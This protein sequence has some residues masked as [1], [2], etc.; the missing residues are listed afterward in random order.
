[1][2]AS[3]SDLAQD[4]PHILVVDPRFDAYKALAAAARL[5][6]ID[7]HFRSAGRD[8]LKLAKRMPVDAW[9]IGAELDDMSGEDFVS[10]LKTQL[11]ETNRFDSRSKVALVDLAAPGSRPWSI[12]EHEARAVGADYM[13]SHPITFADLEQLLG[14]PAE[15]R[16][17]FIVPGGMQKA[18]FALPVSVGAAVI[19]IA[20]LMMG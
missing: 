18:F 1:M 11:T 9:L 19:A 2:N 10:L 12:A 7:L 8:A 6:K 17:K 3:S 15:E 16:A 13:L 4:V 20:V 14:L 5:G